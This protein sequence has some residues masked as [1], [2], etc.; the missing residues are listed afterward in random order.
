MTKTWTM[1]EINHFTDAHMAL[2]KARNSNKKTNP[3]AND[4]L[5]NRH[6]LLPISNERILGILKSMYP[7]FE[8]YAIPSISWRETATYIAKARG[9]HGDVVISWA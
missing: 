9:K 4:L 1:V 8:L 2:L 3:Y 6:A 5:V 7:S